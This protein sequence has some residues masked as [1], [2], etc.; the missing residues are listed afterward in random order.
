MSQKI[1]IF[2]YG[3]GEPIKGFNISLISNDPPLAKMYATNESFSGEY[4][5]YC[6]KTDGRENTHKFSIQV[7]RR[8]IK[9]IEEIQEN[10]FNQELICIIFIISVVTSIIFCNLMFIFYRSSKNSVV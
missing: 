1:F 6:E 2:S 4:T 7:R 5:C 8:P 10:C 9:V 3:K